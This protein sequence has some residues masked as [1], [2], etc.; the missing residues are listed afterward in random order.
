M[1]NRNR[2]KQ[3][4]LRLSDEESEQLRK[5]VEQSG[6]SQQE[7]ILRAVLDKPVMNTDGIKELAP[8]IK[9]VANNLN[10]T[11]KALNEINVA[12]KDSSF[13]SYRKIGEVL[14]NAELNQK[15]LNELWLL[16]RQFLQRQV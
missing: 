3:V 8:T 11:T 16:L 13:F 6:M 2:A 14:T 15:E 9:G 4:I 1:A 12:L 10:Q 5:K 7:Y